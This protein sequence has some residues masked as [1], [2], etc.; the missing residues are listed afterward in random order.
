MSQRR[1]WRPEALARL[2]PGVSDALLA[3]T[4]SAVLGGL[5]APVALI[6]QPHSTAIPLLVALFVA[7]LALA[8]RRTRPLP[9][10][11]LVSLAIGAALLIS[12]FALFLPSTLVF[13][14]A[15]YSACAHGR[16]RTPAIALA[17]GVVLALAATAAFA[18]S[19]QIQA[20]NAPVPTLLLAGGLLAVVLAAWSLGLAH[21]T[22][23]A[24]LA[25]HSRQEERARITAEMHDVIAHS[26]AVIV[27]QAKGGRYA[28]ELAGASL[29]VVEDT[30]RAALTDMRGLLGVLRTDHPGATAD[31]RPQP[32][33]TDLPD[34]VTRVRATGLT[35]RLTEH[36]DRH[37]LGATTELAAYRVV[38]E[39]L[40]NTLR[41]AGAKAAV[42]YLTWSAVGLTVTV[43]DDGA[44]PN[45][46]EGH[47][48]SGMRART[49][50]VGGRLTT[51]P[52][53]DGGFLVSAW[54]PVRP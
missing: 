15:L 14:I 44:G 49:E 45:G 12:A 28:P 8:A 36:G 33:L 24:S 46:T 38:Q 30:A 41:H 37:A 2:R 23:L 40:T 16:G 7:H 53:P 27:S 11:L 48:L 47:G 39:A 35:V 26:L 19:P 6:T 9:A 32:G 5:S 31:R 22:R 25:E 51:G 54:L 13:P 43:I 20:A 1:T 17:A 21:R 52:G 18:G 4:L 10:F 50:A 42:V 29:Q 34:L 3:A